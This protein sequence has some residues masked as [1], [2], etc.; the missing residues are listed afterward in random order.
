M[1]LPILSLTE[2]RF[3]LIGVQG[4]ASPT[5]IH[6]MEHVLLE[7]GRRPKISWLPHT[8]RNSKTDQIQF[9]IRGVFI[10]SSFTT[11]IMATAIL[12]LSETVFQVPN[13]TNDLRSSSNE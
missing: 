5:T 6:R 10:T 4:S 13:L 1:S 2:M 12:R 9:D 7:G 8:R 11:H 3:L